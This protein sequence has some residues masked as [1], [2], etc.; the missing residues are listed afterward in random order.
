MI[1]RRVDEEIEHLQAEAK[2]NNAAHEKTRSFLIRFD[3]ASLEGKLNAPR[4]RAKPKRFDR[5]KERRAAW[6]AFEKRCFVILIG[7]RQIDDLDEELVVTPETEVVF[8]RLVPLV[9]G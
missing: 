7:D 2:K 1:S 6:E 9:G 5:T 4:T 8:L 3:P